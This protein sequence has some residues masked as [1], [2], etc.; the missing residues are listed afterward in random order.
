MALA[1][2]GKDS[3][4][5]EKSLLALLARVCGPADP[6]VARAR[7]PE[8][9]RALYGRDEAA[10]AVLYSESPEQ[11]VRELELV[12]DSFAAPRQSSFVWIT[13]DAVER[14]GKVSGRRPHRPSICV[15]AT[16]Q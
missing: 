11:A 12:L 10:N 15:L 13:P 3:R 6:T 5:E 4:T 8:S 14:C 7:H 16:E 1:V 9:L 2:Q